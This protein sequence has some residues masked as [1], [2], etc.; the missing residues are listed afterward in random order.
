MPVCSYLVIPETGALED[1]AGR[2]RG[3][4]GCD[5]AKAENRGL[6]LLVTDTRGPEE[7]EALRRRLEGMDGI[8]ALVLAFGEIDPEVGGSVSPGGERGSRSRSLPVVD[9]GGIDPD[10]PLP[11]RPSDLE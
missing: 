1:L 3:L 2:L 9:P 5:V 4:P 10:S 6:L 11:P 8:H 7:D